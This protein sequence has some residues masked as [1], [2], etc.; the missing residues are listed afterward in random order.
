MSERFFTV[1]ACQRLNSE[2]EV[3]AYLYSHSTIVVKGENGRFV[4]FVVQTSRE[5]DD[6]AV[7]SAN[8]QAARLQ[9]GMFGVSKLFLT[10]QSARNYLFT[11]H[12]I[13]ASL[14][15]VDFTPFD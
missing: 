10:E 7:W 14:P 8:Y 5:T 9:S 1:L 6:D 3:N 13:N 12:G 15:P 2:R 4:G 11:E